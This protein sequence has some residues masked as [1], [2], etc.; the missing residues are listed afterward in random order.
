MTSIII[1]NY[2]GQKQEDLEEQAVLQFVSDLRRAQNM[3][4]AVA[5]CCAGE[6]VCTNYNLTVSSNKYTIPCST[7]QID[8]SVTVS[9]G[10]ISFW[11][12]DELNS[13]IT[14]TGTK[15]FTIGTTPITITISDEGKISW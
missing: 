3:A 5:P 13:T 10:T 8:L 7:N 14:I 15:V 1:V 6:V 4:M 2:S 11:P 12:I 9:P